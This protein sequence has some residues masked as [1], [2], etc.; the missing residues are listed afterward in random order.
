MDYLK[1]ENGDVSDVAADEYNL[2]KIIAIRCD[3]SIAIHGIVYD[4]TDMMVYSY[5]HDRDPR[6]YVGDIVTRSIEE[7]D[8]IPG[9][10]DDDNDVIMVLDTCYYNYPVC[11]MLRL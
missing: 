8:Y 10:Y 2:D 11:E 5:P 3:G 4:I 1:Y 9:G 7:L 6:L